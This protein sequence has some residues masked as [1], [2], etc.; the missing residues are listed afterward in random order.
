MSFRQT[1]RDILVANAGI[2]QQCADQGTE[3]KDFFD[4][5]DS[6]IN[7]A[8]RKKIAPPGLLPEVIK[9][10][11]LVRKP[12]SLQTLRF[13]L[14]LTNRQGVEL[15]RMLHRWMCVDVEN[16]RFAADVTANLVLA[17]VV[18][19]LVWFA[20]SLTLC[21]FVPTQNHVC[22]FLAFVVFN[23]YFLNLC[24]LCIHM[25]EVLFEYMD[26]ILLEWEDVVTS[27]LGDNYITELW[28]RTKNRRKVFVGEERDYKPER[29]P[30][31]VRAVIAT[32]RER[33]R[34]LDKPSKLL[35][36][37]ITKQLRNRILTLLITPA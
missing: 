14:N 35:G 9:M 34:S 37:V 27:R 28:D 2:R 12:L 11:V 20:V 33:I 10:N 21:K 8:K 22:A 19:L 15:H 32:A 24:N 17:C 25:N 16:E 31:E 13:T 4:S 29:V 18:G 6:D 26:I 36:I 30:L 1:F 5:G 23:F 7:T 3:S